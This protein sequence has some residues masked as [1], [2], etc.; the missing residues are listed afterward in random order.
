MRGK[1]KKTPAGR[2]AHHANAQENLRDHRGRGRERPA[3]GAVRQLHDPLH[4]P[5]PAAAGLQGDHALPLLARQVLRGDLHRRL[6]PALGHGG[7]QIR[8]ALRALLPALPLLLHGYRGPAVDPALADGAQ[9]QLQGPARAAHA[10]R[11]ARVPRAQGPAL[12]PQHPHHQPRA[13]PLAGVPAR[14]GDPGVWL[15]PGLGAHHLQR[16]A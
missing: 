2:E 7:L 10:P 3:V 8:Q 16:R 6:L 12:F 11:A 13:A 5:E 9:Q 15:H 1:I 4:H 14:G